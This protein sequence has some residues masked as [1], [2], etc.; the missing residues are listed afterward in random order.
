MNLALG[1]PTQSFRMPNTRKL[2]QK[3]KYLKN[4]NNLDMQQDSILSMN[5]TG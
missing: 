3:S 2:P 5:S 4:P 1:K